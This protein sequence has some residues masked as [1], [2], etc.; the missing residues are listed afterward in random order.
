MKYLV[1]DTE[2]SGLFDYKQPADAP[3]QPRLASF[4]AIFV[5]DDMGLE[6]EYNAFVKPDG[7]T[8]PPEA[9]KINGLTN[10]FLEA[11][12][13]PVIEVLEVYR[14][15]VAEGRVVVAHNSQHDSKQLRAEFRRAGLP[16]L[17]EQTPNI[18][19]M[20]ALT[21]ICK[22]PPN[23]NRGGYKWPKLSEACVFFHLP[24]FG[25]HSAKNDALACYMLLRKMA[26]L[27][28]I[29]EPAVHYAKEKPVAVG[30]PAHRVNL[31]TAL[32]KS[33]HQIEPFRF[34]KEEDF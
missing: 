5:A 4:S 24:E 29:P 6:R 15:A 34:E 11:N 3:G 14:A 32:E 13:V 12:G 7:W 20:R 9:T 30:T 28:I 1:I 23:G 25:D 16:D 19:T 22:I 8:M 27:K 10:E 21:D 26:E 17:F 2:G 31:R 33:V 18:C